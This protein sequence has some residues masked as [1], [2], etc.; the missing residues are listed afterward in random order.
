MQAIPHCTVKTT[1][2]MQMS[3]N[4]TA[5]NMNT[6]NGLTKLC[7]TS[8]PERATSKQAFSRL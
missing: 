1:K 3:K 2:L 7:A 8:R 6:K 4:L 5:C